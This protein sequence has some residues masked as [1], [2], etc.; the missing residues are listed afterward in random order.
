M[1]FSYDIGWLPNKLGLNET[2]AACKAAGINTVAYN[3]QCIDGLYDVLHHTK[4]IENACMVKNILDS[5]NISCNQTYAPFSLKLCDERLNRFEEN[6]GELVRA[7]EFSAKIGANQMVVCAV[8][9]PKGID[10]KE[11]NYKIY[12]SL[13]PFCEKFGIQLAISSDFPK[14][15]KSSA[16]KTH[17]ATAEEYR[18]FILSFGSEYVC[19]CLDLCTSSVLNLTP[20][21]FIDVVGNKIL[22]SINIKDAEKYRDIHLQA[23]NEQFDLKK[24]REKLEE[25][26]YNGDFTFEC[27][28]FVKGYPNELLPA[29]LKLFADIGCFV[30]NG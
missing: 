18:D 27:P 11:K 28:S 1:D 26:N 24:I 19:A 17:W 21:E 16:L 15:F 10:Q 20:F 3:F 2:L 5:Y 8:Q 29:L 12:K 23:F 6:Y 30:T 22:K 4:Y 7:L 13:I 14:H 25:I 9:V